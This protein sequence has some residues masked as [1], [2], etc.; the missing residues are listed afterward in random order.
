MINIKYDSNDNSVGSNKY[1]LD[2]NSNSNILVSLIYYYFKYGYYQRL[3]TNI[4]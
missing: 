2:Y 4:S 3:S 1:G